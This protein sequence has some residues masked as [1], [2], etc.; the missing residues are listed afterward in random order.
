MPIQ[1]VPFGMPTVLLQNVVYALPAVK[2]LLFTD[3]ATPTIQVSN[4]PTFA[5]NAAV[6]LT[7]GS[8]TIGAGFIRS[9]AG[10]ANVVLSRD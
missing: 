7:A 10:N 1:L 2:A 9:T 3:T 4:D 5:T 6:T 8:A